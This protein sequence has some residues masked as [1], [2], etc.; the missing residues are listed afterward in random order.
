ML[1]ML[2]Y[3]LYC[4]S[5][6]FVQHSLYNYVVDAS[7]LSQRYNS[8]ESEFL[9]FTEYT[10]LNKAIAKK[11]TFTP[12]DKSQRC[13]ALM[14]MRSIYSLYKKRGHSKKDRILIIKKIKQDYS[15]FLKRHYTPNI[16]FLKILKHLLFFNLN[17]F[18]TICNIKLR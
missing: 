3:I 17:I 12:T 6:K 8:F 18:D 1:F 15:K 4:N 2:E 5:I 11:F 10:R 13:G 14:L 7:T 16:K 9:L